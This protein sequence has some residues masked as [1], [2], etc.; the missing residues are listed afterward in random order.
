MTWPSRF[1]TLGEK[2][3]GPNDPFNDVE[4]SAKNN[5]SS[6]EM[7]GVKHPGLPRDHPM[8]GKKITSKTKFRELTKSM[9]YEEVGTAFEKGYDPQVSR[10]RDVTKKT[11]ERFHERLRE[12]KQIS[13][14]GLRDKMNETR[15]LSERL[16][17]D[18]RYGKYGN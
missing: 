11:D 12:N 16:K 3:F 2:V 5:F 6:D 8:Y 1:G 10:E 9:G 7:V 13:S 15:E 18:G 4:L 17:R 14:A